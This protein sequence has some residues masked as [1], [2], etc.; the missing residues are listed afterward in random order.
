MTYSKINMSSEDRIRELCLDLDY[1][2]P[3]QD[4]SPQ[5]KIST[6]QGSREVVGQSKVS[7]Q[8]PRKTGKSRA[9]ASRTRGYVGIRDKVTLQE[10]KLKLSKKA[11][12]WKLSIPARKWVSEEPV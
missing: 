5:A 12:L 8:G 3:I 6:K 4:Q 1:Q 11:A 2:M 10:K 7:N 9:P